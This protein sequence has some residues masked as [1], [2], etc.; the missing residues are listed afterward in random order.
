LEDEFF[1]NALQVSDGDA[2]FV[3]DELI[4]FLSVGVGFVGEQ[5]DGGPSFLATPTEVCHVIR[6]SS[7]RDSGVRM[8]LCLAVGEGILISKVGQ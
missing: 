2:D 5:E 3:G 1:A 4:G 7:S 6:R 8:I